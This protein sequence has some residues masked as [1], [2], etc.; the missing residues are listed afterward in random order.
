MGFWTNEIFHPSKTGR[1][2]F[3]WQKKDPAR[4]IKLILLT[5]QPD[6]SDWT[7]ASALPNA[8]S[9]FR[10]TY[11]CD[12]WDQTIRSQGDSRT[13]AHDVKNEDEVAPPS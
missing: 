4:W 3:S 1:L 5:E 8:H 11:S 9:A 10:P 12:P 7:L 13:V 2:T 6:R